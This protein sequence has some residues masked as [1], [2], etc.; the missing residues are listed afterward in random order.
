MSV[1]I[2]N[3]Y[4]KSPIISHNDSIMDNDGHADIRFD[5]LNM[6]CKWSL[7]K[8]RLGTHKTKTMSEV[9]STT[10]KPHKQKGTGRARRGSF[11]APNCVGGGVSFGPVVRSHAFKLNKKYRNIAL[12]AAI[13]FKISNGSLF[14]IDKDD[15]IDFQ[16]T[17]NRSKDILNHFKNMISLGCFGKA[18]VD[19]DIRMHNMKILLISS[20]WKGDFLS[21]VRNIYSINCISGIEINAYDILNNSIIC[22]DKELYCNAISK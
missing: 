20:F 9:K 4:K 10:R 14:L 11:V 7:A 18:F 12:R 8:R 5:I 13:N 16:S 17:I 21:R 22:M 15:I 1:S 3:F 6:I 2:V 19:L